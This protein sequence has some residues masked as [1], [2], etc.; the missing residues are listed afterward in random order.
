M[1]M[2]VAIIG[3]MIEDIEA[4]EKINSTLHEYSEYI[5]SRLG[6]PY[7]KRNI[8]ILSVLIDAPN[9]VIN[10]LSGKL[11]MIKGVNT[12]AMYYKSE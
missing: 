6:V 2:R 5:I 12:K 4:S 9:D 10:S 3:M 8:S 11:G 7:P 1:E